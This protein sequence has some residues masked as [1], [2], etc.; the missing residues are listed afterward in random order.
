MIHQNSAMPAIW[1]RHSIWFIWYIVFKMRWIRDITTSVLGFGACGGFTQMNLNKLRVLFHW[2]QIFFFWKSQL[3]SA[4]SCPFD[5]NILHLLSL[6]CYIHRWPHQSTT[7]TALFPVNKFIFSYITCKELW[8]LTMLLL[9]SCW[10]IAGKTQ[11]KLLSFV[12]FMN[13]RTSS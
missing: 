5:E 9:L 12:C 6:H 7:C 3:Q 13:F 10:I 1:Q 4:I 2:N 11:Y 8:G